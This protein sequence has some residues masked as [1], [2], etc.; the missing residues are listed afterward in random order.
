M[1]FSYFEYFQLKFQLSANRSYLVTVIRLVINEYTCLSLVI[2]V[3]FIG[4]DT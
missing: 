1:N 4:T 3:K 2:C